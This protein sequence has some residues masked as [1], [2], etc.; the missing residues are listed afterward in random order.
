[1]VTAVP[2]LYPPPLRIWGWGVNMDMETTR[3][4]EKLTNEL[5][6]TQLYF[7]QF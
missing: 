6:K 4:R 5:K 1:L 3:K 2:P 7:V